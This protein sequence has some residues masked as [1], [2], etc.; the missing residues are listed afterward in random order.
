MTTLYTWYLHDIATLA[1]R[2]VLHHHCLLELLIVNFKIHLQHKWNLHKCYNLQLQITE[3]TDIMVAERIHVNVDYVM[4]QYGTRNLQ[5][6]WK[7]LNFI[8]RWKLT[9]NKC[10]PNDNLQFTGIYVYK[11]KKL[12]FNLFYLKNYPQ[13]WIHSLEI[14]INSLFCQN[15]M[16]FNLLILCNLVPMS[17]FFHWNM[18]LEINIYIC[19]NHGG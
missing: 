13:I 15:S 7:A 9:M 17:T 8:P 19:G 10:H 2:S 1:A 16:Y 11:E 14:S 12:T 5:Q 3:S 6:S 4:A 18:S